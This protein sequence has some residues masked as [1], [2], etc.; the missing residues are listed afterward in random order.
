MQIKDHATTIDS[1][2]SSVEAATATLSALGHVRLAVNPALDSFLPECWSN[3]YKF[4]VVGIIPG[5]FLIN[6]TDP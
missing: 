1:V 5:A 2:C 4:G 3:L 6:R